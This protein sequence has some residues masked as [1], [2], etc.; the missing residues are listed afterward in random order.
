MEEKINTKTIRSNSEDIPK[1]MKHSNT[2]NYNLSQK[3]N[4][5]FQKSK[6]NINNEKKS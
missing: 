3:Y 6:N 5:L 1:Q 4:S 2:M